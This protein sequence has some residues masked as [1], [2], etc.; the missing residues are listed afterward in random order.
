MEEQLFEPED[1][2]KSERYLFNPIKLNDLENILNILNIDFERKSN[3]IIFNIYDNFV[4]F[5]NNKYCLYDEKNYKLIINY[6]AD[7]NNQIPKNISNYNNQ[8]NLIVLKQDNYYSSSD[9]KSFS[10][11]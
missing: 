10:V 5:F 4:F 7:L 9:P 6:L 8:N 3:H 1:F 11:I 2:F